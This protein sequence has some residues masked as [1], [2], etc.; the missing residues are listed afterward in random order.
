MSDTKQRYLFGL[1]TAVGVAAF[2][3]VAGLSGLPW[4]ILVPLAGLVVWRPTRELLT[5]YEFA[6]VLLILLTILVTIGTLFHKVGMFSAYW[7][8]GLMA[9]MGLSS[10]LCVILKF[11][12]SR[13]LPYIIIHISIIIVLVGSAAKFYFKEIGFIHM[14]E[15]YTTD[16]MFV[17]E[18]G[19]ITEAKKRLPFQVRL[20]KFHVEFY[21]SVPQVYVFENQQDKPSA[22]LNAENGE[23]AVVAGVRIKTLGM[24]DKTYR[25]VPEHPPVQ[26]RMAEMEVDG[27]RGFVS[28]GQ[29][30][31]HESLAFV[32]HEKQGEPKVYRST[33]STLDKDGTVMQQKSIVVNDPLIQ[34]GWWLYQSNWD[35]KNHRYSGIQAV[36]DPGLLVVFAGLIIL[37][38]GTLL[39]VRFR[40][41]SEEG[42]A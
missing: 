28:Q 8:M 39:K 29:P 25:P 20:D 2:G 5:S 19:K 17:M 42:A 26:V 37:A 18:N 40:K 35:P 33:L 12:K 32:L 24:K 36:R 15:G 27:Q 13:G 23:E 11:N 30:V 9:L 38:L 41:K 21:D 14:V 1:L 10:T 4:L 3:L 31:R 7:F 6:A 22:V 16:E 34:D